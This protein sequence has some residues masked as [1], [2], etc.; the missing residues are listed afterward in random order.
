MTKFIFNF[1]MYSLILKKKVGCPRCNWETITYQGCKI[2]GE[3]ASW[4]FHEGR[5]VGRTFTVGA[6]ASRVVRPA[7]RCVLPLEARGRLVV[8]LHWPLK[9]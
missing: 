1:Y 4:S 9:H 2:P 3:G 6:P 7:G 8:R 5:V